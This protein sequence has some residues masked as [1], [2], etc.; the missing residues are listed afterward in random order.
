MEPNKECKE[1][2]A[3]YHGNYSEIC[4]KNGHDS[5]TELLTESGKSLECDPKLYKL[6]KVHHSDCSACSISEINGQSDPDFQFLNNKAVHN[7][8]FPNKCEVF[9]NNSSEMLLDRLTAGIKEKVFGN[10]WKTDVQANKSADTL[11]KYENFHTLKDMHGEKRYMTTCNFHILMNGE[12]LEEAVVLTNNR[13]SSKLPTG[14]VLSACLC[15]VSNKPIF[16][17]Q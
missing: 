10:I 16:Q 8:I 2:F 6:F 17:F 13:K 4:E 5:I 3:I 14:I 7:L 12:N 15:L 1:L 11:I 9:R